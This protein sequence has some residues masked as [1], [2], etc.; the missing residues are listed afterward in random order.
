MIGHTLRFEGNFAASVEEFRKVLA[1][2]FGHPHHKS[3]AQLQV[4][5]TY[6]ELQNAPQAKAE[7]EKVLA[8]PGAH[9]DHVRRAKEHLSQI[10][11]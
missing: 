1:M 2:E 6:F 7:F 10:R 4:G 9:E 5:I 8:I 11:L 3:D